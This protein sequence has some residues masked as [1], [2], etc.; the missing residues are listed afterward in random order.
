MPLNVFAQKYAP[1]KCAPKHTDVLSNDLSS[2]TEMPLPLTDDNGLAITVQQWYH[3]L[4]QL[5]L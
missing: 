3:R 1:S 4:L 5:R 2:Q